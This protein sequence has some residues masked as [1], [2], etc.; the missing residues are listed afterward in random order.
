[1]GEYINV[2]FE[3]KYLKIHSSIF[4]IYIT[5]LFTLEKCPIDA[6]REL[7]KYEITDFTKIN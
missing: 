2:H 5:F 4:L 1:M 6:S 3:T 7:L